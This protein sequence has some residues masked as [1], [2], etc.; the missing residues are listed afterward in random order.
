MDTNPFLDLGKGVSAIPPLLHLP[1][2]C[3]WA[4]EW[5]CSPQLSASGLGDVLEPS[6]GGG[7]SSYSQMR[8]R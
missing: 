6:R 7:A 4:G 5:L 2:P 1:S 3:C 8:R